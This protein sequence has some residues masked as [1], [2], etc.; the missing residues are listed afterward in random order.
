VADVESKRSPRLRAFASRLEEIAMKRSKSLDPAAVVILSLIAAA[1]AIGAPEYAGTGQL[2]PEQTQGRVTYMT[3]GIGQDE[4]MALRGEER[5]FP[6]SLE[7]IRRAKPADEFL[8]NVN[9]TI[10]DLQGTT[11]FQALAEGPYLLASLPDGRYKVTADHDGQSKT[12][13]VVIA[14]RRPERIVFEW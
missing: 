13:E 9:V 8:A 6:L 2:P 11:E 10:T 3:G 14:A 5:R 7:F 1:P 12:R 4:A